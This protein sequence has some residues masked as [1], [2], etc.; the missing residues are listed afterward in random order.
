MLETPDDGDIGYIQEVDWLYPDELHDLHSD[1]PLAPTK[2]QADACW[3]GDY[4]E[5]LLND[6]QMIAPHSSNKIDPNF[7]P[8]KE[9]YFTLSN[10]E[11]LRAVGV[12]KYIDHLLL[13]SQ[14]G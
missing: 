1:F 4:Q 14:N 7:A 2:Q 3:L 11:A 6:M 8:K 10:I 12:K 13:T 5:E 9:L